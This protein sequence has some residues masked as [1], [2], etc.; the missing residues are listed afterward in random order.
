M[1]AGGGK[2]S[3]KAHALLAVLAEA[4][5]KVDHLRALVEQAAAMKSGTFGAASQ[6]EQAKQEAQHRLLGQI[7]RMATDVD[8]ILGERGFTQGASDIQE[9]VQL[10]RR[11]GRAPLATMHRMRELVGTLSGMLDLAERDVTRDG[12]TVGG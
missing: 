8:Q 9:L 10:A 3:P 1:S 6:T 4:R 12:T 11:G 2:L 7:A 5:R